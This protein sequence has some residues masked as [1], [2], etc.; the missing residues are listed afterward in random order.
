MLY[1]LPLADLKCAE[2]ARVLAFT[3][4]CDAVF[5]RKMMSMG[6]LPNSEVEVVR[7]APL[8]DPIEIKVRTNRLVI[9]LADA[10]NIQVERL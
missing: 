10:R 8:F 5:R 7:V 9:R 6:V 1:S 2:R 3:A 4:G